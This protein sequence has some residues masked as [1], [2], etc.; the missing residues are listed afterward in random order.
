MPPSQE[1]QTKD[2]FAKGWPKLLLQAEGATILGSSIW[3]YSR[4]NQSWWTFA[5]VLLLPDLGMAGY[6]ANTSVGA[7]MYNTVHT[8]VPPLLILCA[9][10]ARGNSAVSGLAVC[11]LAHIGMDR[12]LGYGLKYG[13]GF[14]HTHMGVIGAKK[15]NAPTSE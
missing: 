4:F 10:L 6:L 3:A 7:A 2:G 12:M 14:T 9:A 5:G 8:E 13:T 1:S 15:D 11:W